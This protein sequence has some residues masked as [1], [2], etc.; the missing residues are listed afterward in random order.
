MMGSTMDYGATWLNQVY[1]SYTNVLDRDVSLNFYKNYK[2]PSITGSKTK[3]FCVGGK[4]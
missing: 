1:L 2:R 3:K 4:A